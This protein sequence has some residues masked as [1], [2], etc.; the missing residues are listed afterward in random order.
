[1]ACCPSGPISSVVIVHFVGVRIWLALRVDLWC[2]CLDVR[3]AKF[4]QVA[5]F[6]TVAPDVVTCGAATWASSALAPAPLVVD[7]AAAPLLSIVAISA[8]DESLE[9]S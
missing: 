6:F 4:L 5:R 9:L 8:F 3:V 1:M 7:V 2:P